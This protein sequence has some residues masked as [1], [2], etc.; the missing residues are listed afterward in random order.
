MYAKFFKRVLDLFLSFFA[1]VCLSPLLIVLT[2]VGAVAMK[3]NPFFTQQRPGLHERIFK[4]IK[5]RTMTNERDK[6][7]NLLPD[8]VRLNRYGRFLRSTS[9]DELPEL[10]NIF[11]GDMSIVGPRPLLVKYLPFYKQEER[12]RHS[13]RPGLTGF[14]QVNGRNNL[15]WDARIE[16]D[17]QYV[18]K[19][20][21]LGDIKII[22]QTVG[23]VLKRSDI[24]SGED[25]LV[26]QD[27]DKERAWMLKKE[28]EEKS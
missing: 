7:G 24:A 16:L 8:S 23:K 1:L 2:L 15:D 25:Q 20:T 17:V 18:Q 14:A 10:I 28:E 9:L 4:L 13:V 11:K 3:G 27:L 21:F 19:I 26:M 6:D 5:F 12:V 22:L